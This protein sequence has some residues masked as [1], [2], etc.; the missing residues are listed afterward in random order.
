MK[1][2]T[3]GHRILSPPTVDPSITV[4]RVSDARVMQVAH[5]PADLMKTP[6]RGPHAQKR[7]PRLM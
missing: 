5:M 4:L 7:A 3:I 6:R 2:Q 1:A